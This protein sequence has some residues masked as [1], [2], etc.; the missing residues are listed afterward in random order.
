MTRKDTV[1]HH[2][3][4]VV[5]ED[6]PTREFL[7]GNLS[8][9]GYRVEAAAGREDALRALATG[10]PQLVI[11]D[12]NGQTLELVDAVRAANHLTGDIDPNT[13][14]L[15]ISA[16]GDELTRIRVL[17]HGGDDVLARPF[18]YQEL[19]ARVRALL[20]R[21]YHTHE[22]GI[23]RVGRLSVD[24]QTHR[25]HIGERR[26]EVSAKEF[27]LL[28]ALA[29]DPTRVFTKSELLR[30][31]WGY[32]HTGT[33][34]TLDSHACRLRRKLSADGDRLVINVWGVG[35]ALTR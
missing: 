12:L 29:S 14:M 5:E 4:L 2:S 22:H 16:G 15:V 34:R 18:S 9:D 32:R 6:A 24:V 21:A 20:R 17:Q 7:A 23:V 35:Y 28:R 3:I 10:R 25:V 13:P 26:V 33:T 1:T 11:G 30:D 27:A 31:I 8:A 19:L